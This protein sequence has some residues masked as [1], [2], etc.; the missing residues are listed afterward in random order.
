VAVL[1]PVFL[2][3][4]AVVLAGSADQLYPFWLKT[5]PG[6][7]WIWLAMAFAP[8]IYS[9]SF[10]LGLAGL[11]ADGKALARNNWAQLASVF[12]MCSVAFPAIGRLGESA[13]FLG[14]ALAMLAIGPVISVLISNQHR[15]RA[16]TGA[17]LGALFVACALAIPAVHFSCERV[18]AF[19][20][21]GIL[22]IDALSCVLLWLVGYW[23]AMGEPERFQVH[24]ILG[25]MVRGTA[26]LLG[27]RNAGQ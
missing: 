4:L 21:P 27:R 1:G 25:W 23:L 24:A 15:T 12:I 17:R 26:R 9:A 10:G 2:V 18:T 5:A 22:A 14:Q 19:G 6:I 11:V 3:P 16:G 7:D 13:F 8:A 20:L